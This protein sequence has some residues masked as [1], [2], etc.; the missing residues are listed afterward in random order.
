MIAQCSAVSSMPSRN[1]SSAATVGLQSVE[2]EQITFLV[3]ARFHVS[4]S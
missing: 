3:E 4:S 1:A 2:F